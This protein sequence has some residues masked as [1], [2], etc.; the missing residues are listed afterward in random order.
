MVT[1]LVR[2]EMWVEKKC[3]LFGRVEGER[4]CGE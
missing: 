1:L 2:I 4:L 3:G